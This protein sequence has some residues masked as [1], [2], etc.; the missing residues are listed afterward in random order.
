MIPSKIKIKPYNSTPIP[1]Y[2]EAR[3]GVTFGSTSIPVVWHVVS[4]SC[5]PVLAGSSALQL[6]II[7][8]NPDPEVFQP[9]LMMDKSKSQTLQDCLAKYPDNFKGLGK[10]HNHQVKLHIDATVKPVNVPPRSIPYH[11]QTRAQDV[12]DQMIRDDVIEEHPP[13]EPAPWVSNAVLAPKSD[14]SIRITLDARNANKAIQSTNIPIPNYEDI[15]SKL[16][17]CKLF[18][19]MDF[20]SAF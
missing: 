2:G 14:G 18:S 11:L 8:F 5:E 4:G 7:A 12:I 10:L 16:T 19:K 3:C 1:L 13:N 15:K 20:K 9:V 17:N 6:G